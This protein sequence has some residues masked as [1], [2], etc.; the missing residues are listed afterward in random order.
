MRVMDM[1]AVQCTAPRVKQLN[2]FRPLIAERLK[3]YPALSA[4]RPFAE[5]R[6]A[7]YPGGI[8]QLRDCVASV[9]PRPEPE[10]VVR[11]ET[12][13]V[14]ACNSPPSDR[15]KFPTPF[16]GAGRCR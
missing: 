13:S 7:G 15:L 12:V 2:P 16:Q 14:I 9:R 4:V 6:A 5:C 10:P 1:P 8:T 3:D 11:F